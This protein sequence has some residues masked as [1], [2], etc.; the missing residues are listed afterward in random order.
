MDTSLGQWE[1]GGSIWASHIF[2]NVDPRP[3]FKG[4]TF[5]GAEKENVDCC[6]LSKAVNCEETKEL[7]GTRGNFQSIG[8]SVAVFCF[9]CIIRPIGPAQADSTSNGIWTIWLVPDRK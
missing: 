2:S 7:G 8:I 4:L 3:I 5:P 9:F 1:S 6:E